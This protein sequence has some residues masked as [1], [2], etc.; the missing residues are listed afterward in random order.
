M[1]SCDKLR[2]L[3]DEPGHGREPQSD[4]SLRARMDLAK[5]DE[6]QDDIVNSHRVVGHN[7]GHEL[8]KPSSFG[9]S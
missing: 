3:H 8:R 1:T 5:T 9:S 7:A 6:S 2:H 4:K